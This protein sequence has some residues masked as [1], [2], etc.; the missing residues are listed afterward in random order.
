M[1]LKNRDG[2]FRFL[3]PTG[4]CD[5]DVTTDISEKGDEIISQAEFEMSDS[6]HSALIT[7]MPVDDLPDDI[8][9]ELLQ[10]NSPLLDANRR[11]LQL[12]LQELNSPVHHAE[13]WGT[14]AWSSDGTEWNNYP[15]FGFQIGDFG[16]IVLPILDSEAQTRV[17]SVLNRLEEPLVGFQYLQDARRVHGDRYK[18]ILATVA[19]ELAIKETLIRLE[20]KLETLLLEVPSPPIGKLYGAVL[21]SVA[22]EESPHKTKLTKGAEKRNKLVHRPERVKF[23]PQE[24]REYLSMVA[25]AIKHLVGLL[26]QRT[27]K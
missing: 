17:Q 8:R 10:V 20:P 14:Q 27:G 23:R 2:P 5:R 26:Q 22:G 11:S 19:A 7:N 21:K 9:A 3:H 18:W 25:S 6:L 16:I 4:Y 1:P 24:V 13:S 12:I 15:F